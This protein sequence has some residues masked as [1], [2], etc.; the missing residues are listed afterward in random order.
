MI[1]FEA[2]STA[3]RPDLHF[4]GYN[5]FPNEFKNQPKPLLDTIEPDPNGLELP[6]LLDGLN[7]NEKSEE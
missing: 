7:L 6:K 4:D 2:F 3:L 5:Y 1:K